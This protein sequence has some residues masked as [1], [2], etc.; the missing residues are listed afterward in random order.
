MFRERASFDWLGLALLVGLT[1][2]LAP[3]TNAPPPPQ[4]DRDNA[5]YEHIM[6]IV[7]EARAEARARYLARDF[8]GAARA[9]EG[10]AHIPDV[11]PL[12]QQYVQYAALR[13]I[14]FDPGAPPIDAFEALRRARTLDVALGDAFGD[15]LTARMR[16]VAPVAA[17]AYR[18]GGDKVGMQLAAH[19]AAMAGAPR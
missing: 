11:Q 7:G 9:L 14:A 15:E 18:A 4:A 16:I 6:E 5:P 12:L 1:V 19:T 13:A 8:D 17:R 2:G 3:R 10:D